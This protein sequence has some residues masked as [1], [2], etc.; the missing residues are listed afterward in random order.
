MGLAING[1][2]PGGFAGTFGSGTY[3]AV[4]DFQSFMC[5]GADGVAGKDTWAALLSSRGN[6]SRKAT[7][8]DTSTRLT[9]VTATAM[10]EAG[11]VDVGRY[12]TNTP[13]GTLDKRL[14]QEELEIIKG[15]GLSVF[16]IYQ[17]YGG[18]ASYFTRS[19][20]RKD[21]REVIKAVRGFGF[22]P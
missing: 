3:Q 1:F 10:K 20:G 13:G 7:G 17:T 2:Y 15:V 4:Y 6:T 9:L 18:Q 14:T 21:A 22:P 16:P 12:L 8:F 11:Y 19:Q 5:L